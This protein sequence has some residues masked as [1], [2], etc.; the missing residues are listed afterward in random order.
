[1]WLDNEKENDKHAN[2]DIG[3]VLGGSG[4]NIKPHRR[5]HCTND[6]GQYPYECSTH[7]TAS[8]RPHTTD[9]DHEQNQKRMIDVEGF[10]LGRTQP[11]EHHHYQR[12][13]HATQAKEC[14]RP[15]GIERNLRD[16]VGGVIYAG[17]SD[18]QRN[19]VARML[20]L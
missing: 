13:L 11:Q 6:D 7:E 12:A 14:R 8:Q 9:D 10:N 3:Q 20:G 17:T 1:M 15:K 4:D 18:I 2:N 5:R 16:S 19:I